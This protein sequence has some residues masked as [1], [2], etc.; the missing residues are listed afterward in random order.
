MLARSA[1]NR[2]TSS[3]PFFFKSLVNRLRFSREFK[4]VASS[5]LIRANSDPESGGTL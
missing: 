2:S 1:L 4:D 5:S 3:S